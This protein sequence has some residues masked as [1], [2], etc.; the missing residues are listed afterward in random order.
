MW[1]EFFF[2]FFQLYELVLNPIVPRFEGFQVKFLYSIFE[3]KNLNNWGK[4]I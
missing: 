4:I 2:F 3:K 1:V